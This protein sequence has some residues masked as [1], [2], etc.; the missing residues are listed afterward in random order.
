MASRGKKDCPNCNKEI[1]AR[2]QLCKCGYHFPSKKIRKDLLEE[3]NKLI[4]SKTNSSKRQGKKDCPN[5]NKE[6]AAATRLCECGYH[7]PSGEV[8]KELLEEKN[9]IKIP[10]SPKIYS[11]EGIGRK[12]CPDCNIIISAVSKICFKCNFDFIAAKKDKV[13]EKLKIRAEKAEERQKKIKEEAQVKAKIR[14]EK[15]KNKP[16]KAEQISPL[17]KELLSKPF[18]FIELEKITPQEHAERILSYGKKRARSL[19]EEAKNRKCWS[20]VDWDFVKT[21]LEKI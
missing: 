12:K 2:T 20:H 17:T 6:I 21:E 11:S 16:T 18:N 9:K 7:F 10:K 13:E 1:D 5:C 3:K 4:V 19:M 14:E 8:K 15:Q